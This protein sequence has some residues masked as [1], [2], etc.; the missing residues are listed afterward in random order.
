MCY[1]FPNLYFHLLI[2]IRQVYSDI[3]NLYVTAQ[4]CSTHPLGEVHKINNG[5]W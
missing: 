2:M 1:L 5:L 4:D 3:W